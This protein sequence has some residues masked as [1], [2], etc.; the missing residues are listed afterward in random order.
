VAP[1]IAE[2]L[3]ASERIA[4]GDRRYFYGVNGV[5]GGLVVA[6]LIHQMTHHVPPGR[7]LISAAARF[8]RPLSWPLMIGADS[9]GGD[10]ELT[11]A[12]ASTA[13]AE[14]TSVE[15]SAIF[16]TPGDLDVPVVT[17]QPPDGIGSPADVDAVTDPLTPFGELVE[18]RPVPAASDPEN[19]QLCGWVRLIQPVPSAHERLAILVDA[20]SASYSVALTDQRLVSTLAMTVEI[21]SRSVAAGFDWVLVRAR[22]TAADSSGIVRETVDMWAEDGRYLASG[23]QLRVVR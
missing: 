19:P 7:Q 22:T 1:S 10:A 14:G 5:H 2:F 15:A 11:I 4:M 12:R 3:H 13:G 16:G 6:M 21:F 20:L 17:P 18:V 23:S 9:N 8:V